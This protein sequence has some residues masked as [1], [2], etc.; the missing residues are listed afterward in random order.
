MKKH[1]YDITIAILAVI[2]I[3]LVVLDF[4]SVISL[5][6]QPYQ[7]I[8]TSILVI[9]AIDY[10]Y[11]FWK[12]DKKGQFFRKNIFD[13]IAIIPFNTIFSFFR[14]ARVFRIARISR[15][16][17][18]SHLVGVTGKLTKHLSDFL[19]TK[20]FIQVLYV[21]A[22]LILVSAAIYSYAENISYLKSIWWA[23]V[24]ATTV[25]YGDLA[26]T[27][28]LGRIAAVM[29]MLLGI[30]FIGLLTSTITEYFSSQGDPTTIDDLEEK[31]DLLLKKVDQLEEKVDQ[32]SDSD[33]EK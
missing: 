21:S 1:I 30:G 12:A 13:L 11:R 2:S 8:D 9:F 33:K 29:L 20:N 3:T 16:A 26:P 31:I 23:L 17:R 4:S 27:S 25:G 32:L 7:S 14:I 15:F 6:D 10:A 18:L 24:T 19:K 5:K 22:A 28:P